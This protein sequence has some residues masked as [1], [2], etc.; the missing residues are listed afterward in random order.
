M[1]FIVVKSNGE[2][3][4]EF[5][6]LDLETIQRNIGCKT[7]EDLSWIAIKWYPETIQ[8][9]L[10]EHGIECD[11][12]SVCVLGDEEG[13]YT[14]SA[15]SLFPRFLGSLLICTSTAHDYEPF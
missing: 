12:N 2:S 15:N 3:D 10:R 13:V 11:L 9:I 7:F 14:S 8:N 6:K 5:G 4:L 1:S